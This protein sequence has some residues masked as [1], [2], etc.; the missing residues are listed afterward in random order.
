MIRR[1]FFT[2][3]TWQFDID[4]GFHRR[5]D[6]YEGKIAEEIG[7]ISI[8]SGLSVGVLSL[9]AFLSGIG[10]LFFAGI[11]LIII[12][13]T[14]VRIAMWHYHRTDNLNP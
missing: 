14:L 12:W 7:Y 5:E 2:E 6:H 3:T 9:A 1:K 10:L 8:F 11:L 4:R 13:F